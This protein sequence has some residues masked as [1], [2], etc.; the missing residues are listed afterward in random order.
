MK[1]AVLSDIHGNLPA[2]EA[3]LADVAR[4]GI[5]TVVN[6]GDILS[7]P[8]WV[9]ETA[10]FL[11]ARN[12]VTVA[13]NHERQLLSVR[14][15][16]GFDLSSS[17]GF[18]ASRLREHQAAWLKTLPATHWLT[19]EVLMVHGTPSSDITYWLETATPGF[20]TNG[21][22]GIRAAHAAEVAQRLGSTRAPLVLCGHSHV[23]RAV[24]CG[25]T[26]IVNPGSVGLQAYSD[27]HGHRHVT[28]NG[29]PHARYAVVE[30][31][32]GGWQVDQRAVPYDWASAARFA[33]DNGR[34]DWAHALLHGTLPLSTFSPRSAS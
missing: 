11:M 28:E 4:Q 22:P 6:C 26:L 24:Q 21:S 1:I 29:S 16:G 20:G 31:G 13:G 15:R 8:L 14:A 33:Q 2:L 19:P 17:D 18:A 5:A 23:P 3:V 12:F 27:D 9:S 32:A 30:K 25:D 34:E 10:D 7:G